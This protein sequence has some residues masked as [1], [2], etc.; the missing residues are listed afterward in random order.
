[1]VYVK[2]LVG[3]RDV[4]HYG[5]DLVDLGVGCEHSQSPGRSGQ[6]GVQGEAVRGQ[7]LPA[8]LTPSPSG[9]RP[10]VTGVLRQQEGHLGGELLLL[11]NL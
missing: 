4:F 7:V 2:Y 9:R 10:L 11:L 1:M 6:G 8:P 5:R 3:H